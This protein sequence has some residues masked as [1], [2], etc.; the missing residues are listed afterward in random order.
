MKSL[1][2]IG[3]NISEGERKVVDKWFDEYNFSLEMVLKAC[4]NTKKTSNPSINYINGILS[5]WY[6]KGIK[7]VDEIE[8]RIKGKEY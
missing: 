2:F 3:R 5:S 8:E 6:S 4:E 7:T 1:G